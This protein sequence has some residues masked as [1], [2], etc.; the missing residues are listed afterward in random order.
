MRTK[1][2]WIAAAAVTLAATLGI[3]LQA[4]A[5]PTA[6]EPVAPVT[7]VPS[8]CPTTY[9]WPGDDVSIDQI[10]A[11]ITANFGFQLT[12]GKWT[13]ANREPIRILWQTLDAVGCT[14]YVK[15]LQGKVNGNVGLNAGSIS[16]FAWGDWSLTR[17]GYVTLDFTKFKQAIDSGDEGRLTR[18]VIHELAHVLNSDRGSDPGYWAEFKRLYSK[19]GRFT[20]YAGSSVT[21]TFGD[22]VGY[23][24]GRCA[25]NNPYDTGR[26]DA[27]YDFAK[28][29]I[30][31]GREFGPA[32]GT[33]PDCSIPAA[34]FAAEGPASWVRALTGE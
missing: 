22:V 21:E 1:L 25:A 34:A 13:D 24:V 9:A 15:D 20:T 33:T 7:G 14:S 10:K 26:F 5:L 29:Y 18:L 11:G 12:G 27:Y 23:Y 16:G 30:F 19:Q 28:D 4:V 31:G 2:S 17:S 32:P 8:P 6:P 3:T